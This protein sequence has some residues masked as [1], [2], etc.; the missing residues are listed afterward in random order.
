MD[1]QGREL[2]D[3]KN[4]G[5]PPG[6][7]RQST[8][9]AV[10]QFRGVL[11]EQVVLS[12]ALDPFLSLRAL[13]SYSCVSVRK[14]RELLADSAHPLPHY[15][16]GSKILVRRSEFDAWMAPYRSRGRPELARA[17]RD[18]GLDRTDA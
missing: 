17:L 1:T 13:A 15:R 11:G 16:L 14:L 8:R 6:K 2:D 7:A 5:K 10:A 4:A 3:S 9:Q 18:F 12:S